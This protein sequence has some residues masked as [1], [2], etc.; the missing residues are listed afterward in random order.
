MVVVPTG[1][2]VLKSGKETPATAKRQ[3]KGAK[4]QRLC[5]RCALADASWCVLLTT[6][7]KHKKNDDD[8]EEKLEKDIVVKNLEAY[9]RGTY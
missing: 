9:T 8:K 1:K 7:R 2:F 5:K 6:Q 4:N 3:Y